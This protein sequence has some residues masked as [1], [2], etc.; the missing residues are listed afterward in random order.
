MAIL[1]SN[2]PY[3]REDSSKI[4]IGMIRCFA[5]MKLLFLVMV[6]KWKIGKLEL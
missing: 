2:A 3:V 5:E 4:Q 1:N 6:E